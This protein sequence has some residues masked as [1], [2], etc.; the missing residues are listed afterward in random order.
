MFSSDVIAL[1]RKNRIA[2]AKYDLCIV[3]FMQRV[4]FFM[5]ARRAHIAMLATSLHSGTHLPIPLIA[6]LL[7]NCAR[8]PVAA[9]LLIPRNIC[10]YDSASACTHHP[11]TRYFPHSASAPANLLNN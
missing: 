4:N 11:G 10:L 7:G 2:R 8:A 3:S 6:A 5:C 9:R 1:S